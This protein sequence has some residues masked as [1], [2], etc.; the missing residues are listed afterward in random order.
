MT[1]RCFK[2]KCKGC[3]VYIV[4]SEIQWH[5][6]TCSGMGL[7]K[8]KIVFWRSMESAPKDGKIILAKFSDNEIVTVRWVLDTWQNTVTGHNLISII[9]IEWMPLI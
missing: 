1:G 8:A 5:C 4:D 2:C 6:P 7:S 3:E 9:P